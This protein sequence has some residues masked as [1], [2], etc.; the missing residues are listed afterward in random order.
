MR[1][2]FCVNGKWPFHTAFISNLGYKP[3]PSLQLQKEPSSE[4][5]KANQTDMPFAWIRDQFEDMV[6]LMTNFQRCTLLERHPSSDSDPLSVAINE[7][8]ARTSSVWPK[9]T[10]LWRP[11][12]SNHQDLEKCHRWRQDMIS[13]EFRK[14][15]P[16]DQAETLQKKNGWRTFLVSH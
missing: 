3:S 6:P 16:G 1:I 13:K 9:K 2:C 5:V 10:R 14:K 8:A 15:A 11:W 12:K 4:F 7:L